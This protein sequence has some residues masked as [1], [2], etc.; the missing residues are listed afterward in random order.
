[1]GF[2][3]PFCARLPRLLDSSVDRA[4]RKMESAAL[5]LGSIFVAALV[6]FAWVASVWIVSDSCDVGLTIEFMKTVEWN[7]M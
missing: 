1:M 5:V 3:A 2:E 6:H 7:K 4:L